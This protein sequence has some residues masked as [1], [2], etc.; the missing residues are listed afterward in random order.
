MKKI[1]RGL[2]SLFSGKGAERDPDA[3]TGK[4]EVENYVGQE[5]AEEN[6]RNDDAKNLKGNLREALPFF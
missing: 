1:G 2:K 3:L 5:D 4:P 6:Y